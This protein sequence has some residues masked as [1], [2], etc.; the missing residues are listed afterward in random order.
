[1]FYKNK[2]TKKIVYLVKSDN[3]RTIVFEYDENGE[4]S[5]G[6]IMDYTKKDFK[7]NYIK[8]KKCTFTGPTDDMKELIL[9]DYETNRYAYDNNFEDYIEERKYQD[10]KEA[11]EKQTEAQRVRMLKELA[12]DYNPNG[13]SVEQLKG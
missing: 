3:K 10:R 9:T 5:S 2:E 7:K 4:T 1:L 8:F 13:I 6:I 11:I 12:D